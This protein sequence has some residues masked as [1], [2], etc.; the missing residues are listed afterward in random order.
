MN[1]QVNDP[2]ATLRTPT[3]AVPDEEDLENVETYVEFCLR[4]NT[5]VF[6]PG[7]A[8][9]IAQNVQKPLKVVMD[10]LKSYGL[11]VEVWGHREV[12]GFR[13][14]DHNRWDGNECAGGSGWENINGFAGRTG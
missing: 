1:T 8:Q 7:D 3:V 12:R 9:R 10:D 13:S 6:R 11:R 4:E 5:Q 14:N 2:Y